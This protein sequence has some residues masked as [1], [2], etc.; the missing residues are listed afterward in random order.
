MGIT[1]TEID[2]HVFLHILCGLRRGLSGGLSGM[3]NE[4]FKTLLADQQCL[5]HSRSP[6]SSSSMYVSRLKYKSPLDWRA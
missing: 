5:L 1:V 2:E 6:H 4:N 3:K